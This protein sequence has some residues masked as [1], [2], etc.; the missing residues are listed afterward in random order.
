MACAVFLRNRNIDMQKLL[1]SI[2][3]PSAPCRFAPVEVALIKNRIIA[4]FPFF[5]RIFSTKD[6]GIIIADICR[7]SD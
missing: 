2:E 3:R 4:G 6:G 7:F 5:L 1:S